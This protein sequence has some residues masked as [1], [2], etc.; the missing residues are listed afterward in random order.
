MAG[1]DNPV[2]NLFE[3]FMGQARPRNISE[4]LGRL[5]AGQGS[6]MSYVFDAEDKY[7][8]F[9]RADEFKFVRKSSHNRLGG[10]LQGRFGLQLGGLAR[11]VGPGDA[12]LDP[13]FDRPTSIF[14]QISDKYDVRFAFNKGSNELYMLSDSGRVQVPLPL[15]HGGENLES[16]L[17]HM[18]GTSRGA[19]KLRFHGMNQEFTFSGLFYEKLRRLLDQGLSPQKF[20]AEAGRISHTVIGE[21]VKGKTRLDMLLGPPTNIRGSGQTALEAKNLAMRTRVTTRLGQKNTLREMFQGFRDAKRVINTLVKTSGTGMSS[22][23]GD[24]EAISWLDQNMTAGQAIRTAYG[25][26]KEFY[27]GL[28]GLSKEMG[29]EGH[30]YLIK[31][32]FFTGEKGLVIPSKL[33]MTMMGP[34]V[35]QRE[36]IKGGFQGYHAARYSRMQLSNIHASGGSIKPSYL[37]TADFAGRLP[38]DAFYKRGILTAVLDYKSSVEEMLFTGDSGAFSTVIGS[39]RDAKIQHLGGFQLS[40]PSLRTAQAV[41]RLTGMPFRGEHLGVRDIRL[42]PE[43]VRTAR[44]MKGSSDYVPYKQLSRGAKSIRQILRASGRFSGVFDSAASRGHSFNIST[45]Y[46]NGSLS[47][48]LYSSS[49]MASNTQEILLGNLRMTAT[50]AGQGHFAATGVGQLESA[51]AEKIIGK[52]SYAKM[53]GVGLSNFLGTMEEHGMLDKAIAVIGG[54]RGIVGRVGLPGGAGPGTLVHGNITIPLVDDEATAMQHV[55]TYLKELRATRLEH[56]IKLAE[57][58]E[59]GKLVT[60]NIH[61]ISNLVNSVRLVYADMSLR[62]DDLLDMNAVKASKFTP[63]KMRTLAWG[64]KMMG[65]D[66][67]MDDPVFR[68]M[69]SGLGK[70]FR[71]DPA[72]MDFRLSAEH[73]TSQFIRSLSSPGFTPESGIL[74]HTAKGLELDGKLLK[75][76]PSMESFRKAKGGISQADL[77]GTILDEKY[78]DQLLHLDL[79]SSVD[80]SGILPNDLRYLPVP[81]MFKR[82]KPTRGRVILDPKHPFYNYLDAIQKFQINGPSTV[83]KLKETLDAAVRVTVNAL[84]G[85]KGLMA[86]MNTIHIPSSM[87]ARLVPD[88]SGFWNKGN[89]FDPQSFFDVRV[90]RQAFTTEFLKKQGYASG[91]ISAMQRMVAGRTKADDF[92][93]VM[94][95]VDP[96]QRPEH[97]SNVYRMF[98]TDDSVDMTGNFRL[99]VAMNPIAM[100]AGER[101]LDKDKIVAHMIEAIM[102]PS[103]ATTAELASRLSKQ[104]G[105]V[106]PILKYMSR[107]TTTG[108]AASEEILSKMDIFGQYVGQKTWSSLGYTISRP[109]ERVMSVLMDEGLEGLAKRNIKVGGLSQGVVQEIQAMFKGQPMRQGAASALNQYMFQAGVGKGTGKAPLES[110]TVGLMDMTDQVRKQG[111]LDI[112]QIVGTGDQMTSTEKLFFNFLSASKDNRM[113]QATEQL[114]RDAGSLEGVQAGL[115]E[116]AVFNELMLKKASRLMAQGIGIPTAIGA[117]TGPVSNVSAI[118]EDSTEVKSL[119]AFMKRIVG[120]IS[121]TFRAVGSGE[122]EQI[123][124]QVSSGAGVTSSTMLESAKEVTSNILTNARRLANS[125]YFLPGI[126]AVGAVAA[127]GYASRPS[128]DGGSL[129]PPVDTSRPADR[130]PILPNYSNVAR[131]NTSR[132]IAK[133]SMN[134]SNNS[135]SSRSSNFFNSRTDSRVVVEDKISPT[136]PWLIRQQMDRVSES[137]FVY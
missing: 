108:G 90:S 130:G 103:N 61:G 53:R 115:M 86:K 80:V 66:S 62:A 120:P 104:Q 77:A 45:K 133:A 6:S 101:D 135:L 55:G 71:F 93:Y 19:Y 98:L 79:G 129:P 113:W 54:G 118:M 27:A 23:F 41:E 2:Q 34:S 22:F 132:P 73:T 14:K 30:H 47:F 18:G 65:F 15:Q 26:E 88:S 92:I 57:Q 51:G 78:A 13:V 48:N 64:S 82:I 36:D 116:G 123:H 70:G 28:A 102:G 126:A 9:G 31:P 3:R 111:F 67:P 121:Q 50:M 11:S 72:S 5:G 76:L 109:D 69:T 114:L 95:G 42:T 4:Y 38:T 16:G 74:R 124:P 84:I 25:K 63:G 24:G 59:L 112:G 37:R 110:L 21:G 58:I 7:N 56:N 83:S 91:E 94:L 33:G 119:S 43:D 136:N 107:L 100:K 75:N 96:A 44:T 99:G 127:Y 52:T 87:P 89:V 8:I 105:Q 68:A 106:S 81:M 35:S 117:L 49:L 137:D 29:F 60:G 39:A 85:K 12:P 128:I 40:N 131:I 10:L 122:A 97:L 20:L 134:R 125:K 32:E 17:V 1:S 46:K